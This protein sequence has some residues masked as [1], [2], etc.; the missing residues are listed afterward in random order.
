MKKTSEL[1]KAL[2]V[3][4][5]VVFIVLFTFQVE[6]RT[7]FSKDYTP[8]AR[9]SPPKSE[10]E[11]IHII[12]QKSPLLSVEKYQK[13]FKQLNTELEKYYKDNLDSAN[14]YF[15][16]LVYPY[17]QNIFQTLVN[18]NP[19]L[20]ELH[21]KLLVSR[22]PIPNASARPN[23]YM[24]VNIGLLRYL[25]NES[26]IAYVMAHELSHVYLKHTIRS[27]T[28]YLDNYKSKQ[29]Q[30]KIKEI[31]SSEYNRYSKSLAL[32]KELLYDRFSYSRIYETESDS[33]GLLFLSN[34]PYSVEKACKMLIVLDSLDFEKYKDSILLDQI[35]NSEN[36]PFKPRWIKENNFL[37]A[38][39]TLSQASLDSIKSHPDAIIRYE[40][41]VKL[42]E[43][44]QQS[45]G[46]EFIQDS[47][48]FY[49]IRNTADF[50]CIANMFNE[51][52]VSYS[53]Y[54]SLKLLHKYP[55][56]IYLKKMLLQNLEK[57]KK[58]LEEMKLSDYVVQPNPFSTSDFKKLVLFLNSIRYSEIETLITEMSKKY[59]IR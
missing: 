15:D 59:P 22:S 57:I 4:L 51:D 13:E 36:F 56:N 17:I 8:L 21:L 43:N 24:E 16:D 1:I 49:T 6:A 42:S 20:K 28:N 45:K 11:Q 38:I 34:T 26:Q 40:N 12:H 58:A 48:L 19:E 7:N 2:R 32:K 10:L 5:L 3:Y 55:D 47:T 25:E 30:Q 54:L 44:I 35:F 46:K 33:L 53:M 9:N 37:R 50:E 23:G 41:A 39:D 31:S 27:Y 29:T 14:Y 52:E 18:S